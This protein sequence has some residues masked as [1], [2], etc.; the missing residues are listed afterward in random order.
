MITRPFVPTS[1]VRQVRIHPV[2]KRPNMTGGTPE[3][4]ARAN[5]QSWERLLAFLDKYLRTR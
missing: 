3:G 2:S 4:Q 1:D 5:E